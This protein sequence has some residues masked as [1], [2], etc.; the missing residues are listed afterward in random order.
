MLYFVTTVTSNAATA[1]SVAA[2]Q[3]PAGAGSLTLTSASVTFGANS[4][5]KITITS[6]S[7]IS[8]RTLTVTGTG[9]YGRAL[10]ETITGPNNTTVTSTYAFLTVTSVTI[11]GAAAGAL[12]V[13]N[14]AYAEGLMYVADTV[15]NP[16]SIGF[17]CISATGTYTV[18]HTFDKVMAAATA[19]YITGPY[20]GA[21][22]YNSSSNTWFDH[23]I[24]ASE[25]GNND[26][27]Y[28]FPVSAVRV[29][30]S[31]EGAVTMKLWQS[32]GGSR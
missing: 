21:Y 20:T 1:N 23:P 16:F 13:G 15:T 2:S 19:A 17:G 14:S 7:N 32:G 11:S 10:S 9:V 4:A 29:V 18:Q 30:M 6:G 28:A 3:T 27:N 12:T 31:A 24:V 8:N 25:T 5:Q 22:T 26:G